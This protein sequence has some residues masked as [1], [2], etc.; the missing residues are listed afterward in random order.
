MYICNIYYV[1]VVERMDMIWWKWKFFKNIKFFN[2]D[3]VITTQ[4]T[5]S[6]ILTWALGR[7]RHASKAVSINPIGFTPR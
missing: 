7:A 5:F 2:Q 1:K 3:L 6:F 4:N